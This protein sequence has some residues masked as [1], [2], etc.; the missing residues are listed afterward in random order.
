[1]KLLC[2]W[3]LLPTA[4]QEAA[5]G[6]QVQLQALVPVVSYKLKV[7]LEEGC[8]L[9]FAQS[10]ASTMTPAEPWAVPFSIGNPPK[11]TTTFGSCG[12]AVQKR[13]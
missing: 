11:P 12:I 8:G 7:A 9:E 2:Q 5:Y 3:H 1:M 10:L 4:L 6:Y 13:Q